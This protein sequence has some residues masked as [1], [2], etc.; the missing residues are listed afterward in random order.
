MIVTDPIADM[1]TRIR[2]ANRNRMPS[3]EVPTSKEKK[4]IAEVLKE[5]G[6]I[7][8]YKFIEDKTQGT[9]KIY[10]KYTV[11]DEAV[12]NNLK[13]ISKPGRRV[14]RKVDKMERV[15]DGLGIAIVSTPKGILTDHEC[16]K[17]KVGGEVLCH[18]W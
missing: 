7:K 4:A 8:D 15:L 14:Y 9:L 10:L 3:V 17:L 11:D 5:N 12:I 16:R 18:I 6:Y 13:R 2:N 1:L